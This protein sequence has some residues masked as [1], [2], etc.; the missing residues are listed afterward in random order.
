V[1]VFVPVAAPD[2]RLRFADWIKSLSI[3]SGEL[4]T[5][6]RPSPMMIAAA[7]ACPSSTRALIGLLFGFGL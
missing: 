5:M 1:E 6:V 3:S 2:G 4:P 7:T